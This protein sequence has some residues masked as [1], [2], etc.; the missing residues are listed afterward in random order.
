[1]KKKRTREFRW[2]EKDFDPPNVDYL[3]LI[4]CDLQE[5]I[6]EGKRRLPECQSSD[7]IVS[8][9]VQETLAS[10][11]MQKNSIGA[12]Q[13]QINQILNQP[14]VPTTVF[15]YIIIHEMIHT[16][17]ASEEKDGKR[18]THPPR[19]WE[20]QKEACPEAKASESWLYSIFYR[21]LCNDKECQCLWVSK[22]WR[23]A[24]PTTPR[25]SMKEKLWKL[26][27]EREIEQEKMQ[28]K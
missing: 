11:Q 19:F 24:F 26:S 4:S 28:G 8:F 22:K 6:K 10:I 2:D 14:I 12:Y 23:R 5:L 17:V 18:I 1:M 16:F 15:L 9:C 27:F 3:P 13:I 7:F 21:F 25:T 20:I